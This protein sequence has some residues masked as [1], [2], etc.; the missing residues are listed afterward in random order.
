MLK[1]KKISD[2]PLAYQLFEH[3]H[4]LPPIFLGT[5]TELPRDY[6][7]WRWE[8]Y[9]G[10]SAGDAPLEVGINKVILCAQKSEHIQ[11]IKKIGQYRS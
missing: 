5:V 1:K 11:K 6:E 2:T 7:L 9:F 10:G 3:L 4:K 8:S